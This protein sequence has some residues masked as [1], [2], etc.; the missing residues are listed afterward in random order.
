MQVD[1]MKMLMACTRENPETGEEYYFC[2]GCDAT[3]WSV[4]G[5]DHAPGCEYAATLE[6]RPAPEEDGAVTNIPDNRIERLALTLAS[7]HIGDTDCL[8]KMGRELEKRLM[9]KYPDLEPWKEDDDG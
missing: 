8:G 6:N 9:S 1:V 4:E 2:P 7:V 5:M 3:G